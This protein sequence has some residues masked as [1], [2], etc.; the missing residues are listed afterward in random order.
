MKQTL[1][2]LP[3]QIA[4]HR[5][6]K[7]IFDV[8]TDGL[9]GNTIHCIVTKV[10][11]GET[12]LFPPD[13]L[14]AAVD[15]LTSADVLIGHNIIGF[16]IP[17]IKKHF[18]VTLTN[19]IEDTLV[20]SRLVNPVLTGGHSLDNW[21]YLLYPN[22]AEKRKAKQPDSWDEYTEEMGKYCIQDVEL[23][24]DIYYALLKQVEEFSQESIDL[25]HS[26]AKIIKEQEVK[27]FMLDEKKATLLSAKLQS[28][29]ATLEKEVHETFKPK[30][31]DDRLIT[32]KFNKDGSLSKVPKLTDEELIKVKATDYEPFMR[33]KWVEF[34]LASRKQIGEYLIDFGWKPKKFTPTGQPIVDETTLE[35]VKGIPEATLIAEFMMLQKRVAQVNSWLELAKDGRVHGFVI[36]NGAI[37]GRMTHRNPNVAQTPSSH[38]PY[39][40]ECREC[41]TVPEGYKLV[42]IDASGLELRVLAHYMK[43]KDY[44]NEIISGD[45][46]STNQSLAGLEQR[47]QAKTF[48]YALI[49]GAG[50]SKIGSVVGG[51]SKVG[52]S[53]RNRFLNNLP[54]LR[55]LTTSVERAAS[56][57]KYLKALDGRHIHIRKVYSSL[58]TLLQG[59]GAVIMKTALVLLH[60]RIK[61]LNLDASF[62]GNIHDEWQIEVREDQAE[63]VGQLGVQALKDTTEVLKLNCPLDGEYQIG[64]NWSETH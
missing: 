62:V 27:G 1:I 63:Q 10:I 21:G 16:D 48:I 43:N 12:Q 47:S 54:S 11:G 23:N 32:P 61:Q 3:N 37:T 39:G 45:I 36:P 8:E 42:G 18:D 24:A 31:V 25:E 35:R 2:S 30:W 49:Y 57:R 22:D 58:N 46:H 15:I 9:E 28:K 64:D 19:H 29:M 33:Q 55:N 13:N 6:K 14:Q 56:T 59:G 41:W 7:V 38:K 20:V 4:H 40:K 60:N 34:N 51:N 17:V 50:D 26:V 52:A 53:L 5:F 44:I